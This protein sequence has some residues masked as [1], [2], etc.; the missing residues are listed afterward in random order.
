M[1]LLLTHWVEALSPWWVRLSVIRQS[2]IIK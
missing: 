2:K 1:E